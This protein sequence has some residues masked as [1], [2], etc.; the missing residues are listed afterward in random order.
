MSKSYKEKLR[1]LLTHRRMP[2]MAAAFAVALTLPSLG[3]GL[4]MDDFFIRLVIH[5]PESL[6]VELPHTLDTFCFLSG[7]QEVMKA[8]IDYGSLPWWVNPDVKGCFWRP[9]TS[10]THFIDFRLWP[11]RIWLMHLQSVI[12]YGILALA[13]GF[14][15]RRFMGATHA[16]G[17]AAVLFAVEDAHSTPAVWLANRNSVLACLF[18]LVAIGFHRGWRREGSRAK[19]VAAVALF[20]VALLSAEAGIAAMAYITAYALVLDTGPLRKRLLSLMP[21]VAVIICWRLVWSSLDY[22]VYN[23]PLYADPLGEP[24]EFVKRL[25]IYLPQMIT[26][27]FVF[28]A[29]EVLAMAMNVWPWTWGISA[30]VAV[31]IIMLFRP[32]IAA[33]RTARFFALGA[34]FALV[35]ACSTHP[36]GRNLIFVGIGAFGLMA[37]WLM[38]MP[39]DAIWPRMKKAVAVFFIIIHLVIAPLTLL[40]ASS[41]IIRRGGKL[42]ES[43]RHRT[44]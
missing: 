26:S 11:D 36:Q 16:A 39:R 2:L 1:A 42:F 24:V 7:D 6:P 22:G 33:D 5:Q 34:L 21:Y 14:V 44:S 4:F 15:F 31:M 25:F 43:F 38:N 30:A 32:L 18:G 23:V 37:Q 9:V 35:P 40:V 10:I 8:A 20:T 17:L 28:H 27:Q 13:A 12:W 41:V 3:A 19:G 29:A